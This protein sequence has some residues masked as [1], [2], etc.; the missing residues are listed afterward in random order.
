MLLPTLRCTSSSHLMAFF[1]ATHLS[2]SQIS[3]TEHPIRSGSVNEQVCL[4]PTGGRVLFL[5]PKRSSR[6][7]L[8]R[9]EAKWWGKPRAP[10][11]PWP[12]CMF[13]PAGRTPPPAAPAVSGALIQVG[14]CSC[15]W[16]D[17][18]TPFR[19]M[20]ICRRTERWLVATMEFRSPFRSSWK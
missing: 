13:V 19:P 20:W 17:R 18:R 16:M 7:V 9:A 11:S 3:R 2:E 10:R 1:I 14:L 5:E 6:H 8:H 4:L 12:P 15:S